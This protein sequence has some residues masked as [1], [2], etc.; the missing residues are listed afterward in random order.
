MWLMCS[1][2]PL[3]PAEWV[4][5]VS[6]AASMDSWEAKGLDVHRLLKICQN[7]AVID[8]ESNVIRFAHL[9]GRE[10]LEKRCFTEVEANFMVAEC[11]T[12]LFNRLSGAGNEYFR[13]ESGPYEY[14]ITHWM[15]HI[16]ACNNQ[17]MSQQWNHVCKFLDSRRSYY[18][19]YQA[20]QGAPGTRHSRSHRLVNP[21]PWKLGESL[22]FLDCEPPDPVFAR[23][24]L[25]IDMTV[26]DRC[27]PSESNLNRANR[28][29]QTLLFIASTF[30]HERIVRALIDDGAG[31]Y[32]QRANNPLVSAIRNGH[33]TTARLLHQ[34]AKRHNEYY[35]DVVI[36]IVQHE[37][38][39]CLDTLLGLEN[40]EVSEDIL[41]AAAGNQRHGLEM[42]KV[43][44]DRSR[45]VNAT[46][47][48]LV[49]AVG[50]QWHGLDMV[51]LLLD[52]GRDV[53]VT[54]TEAVLVAAVRNPR[55]G[56]DV[57]KVLLDSGRD[58]TVTEAVLVAAVRNT[59]YG[60]DAIKLLLDSSNEFTVHEAVLVVVAENLS[61]GLDIIKLLFDSGRE[62]IVTETVWV[63]AAGNI[64]SG[65]PIISLL[66]ARCI[67]SAITERIL[68]AA[69][70]NSHSGREVIGLLVDG[71]RWTGA[72]L[73]VAAYFGDSTLAHKLLSRGVQFP[74]DS[75]CA[76]VMVAAVE[77]GDT[78]I[79]E[80]FQT[81]GGNLASVDEHGWTPYMT[82]TQ[83]G[84]KKMAIVSQIFQPRSPSR[85]EYPKQWGESHFSCL[86]LSR[87][88]AEIFYSGGYI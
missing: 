56:P 62:L 74:A 39:A 15:T 84:R 70:C 12:A 86:Q 55:H 32:T 13:S 45:G 37:D 71:A 66:L 58:F 27:G 67:G 10:F 69:E 29:N 57:I 46:G 87:D 53:T 6:W 81:L 34:S 43:L 48:V 88:G 8:S 73:N 65:T 52:S 17:N 36:H 49:A 44:L 41:A 9:S 26:G 64:W 2:R 68:V 31:I 79:F 24:F 47:A 23:C 22:G 14:P 80:F 59:W 63:A 61:H 75:S 51:K 72:I 83:C 54:V 1:Q 42:A 78:G 18:L 4:L 85:V 35:N 20:A 38:R 19:W 33:H 11:C 50:N 40:I 77:G 3:T 5:A 60:P 7:L 25:S 16:Q 76:V 82:A 21:I 28:N 30:G